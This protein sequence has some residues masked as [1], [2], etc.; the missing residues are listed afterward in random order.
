MVGGSE[1]REVGIRE[2]NRER[3]EQGE[4][5]TELETAGQQ[6][7]SI[8]DPL[9]VEY[10][11]FRISLILSNHTQAAATCG[12][13]LITVGEKVQAVRQIAHVYGEKRTLIACR[14][15]YIVVV[16]LW[17]ISCFL[18]CEVREGKPSAG[19]VLG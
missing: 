18:H 8:V 3:G 17:C 15:E 14:N 19:Y 12:N 9:P 6:S 11:Q 4:K 7:F 16:Y 1:R 5:Q 10:C 2:G 13:Q